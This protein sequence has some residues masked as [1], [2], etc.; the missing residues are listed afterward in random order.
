MKTDAQHAT[1]RQ[2]DHTGPFG[3]NRARP[4]GRLLRHAAAAVTLMM[5][6]TAVVAAKSMYVVAKIIN[7]DAP[8][9]VHVYDIGADG[10]L[11]Y[12]T[13]FGAP[14][15]GAGMVGITMDSDT[16]YLFSTYEDS[17]FVLVTNATTLQRKNVLSIQSAK[18]L[19]G[20]VY[21][22]QRRLLYCAEFGGETL[23]V[24]QVGPAQEH[25][26]PR[27]R[28]ALQTQRRRSLR[29]RAGRIQ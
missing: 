10:T 1:Q 26:D 12:Q 29:H 9:P 4:A 18:N 14:F 8:I 5:L 13:E 24:G 28:L 3:S 15:I 11:T 25:P 22:H 27:R 2:T 19:A 6:M 23:F 17:G 21:D 16:G 7:F 20:T